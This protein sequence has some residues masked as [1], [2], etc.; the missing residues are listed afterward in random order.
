MQVGRMDDGCNVP[1]HHGSPLKDYT[2]V[3]V[4]RVV[5]M[6]LAHVLWRDARTRNSMK[7]LGPGG[8]L[9]P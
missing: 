1:Q 4:I 9:H 6:I 7:S 5:A 8:S 3:G 2:I